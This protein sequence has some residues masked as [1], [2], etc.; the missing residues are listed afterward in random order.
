VKTAGNAASR[1]PSRI[2]PRLSA[3]ASFTLIE[4]LAVMAVIVI[5][6][7]IIL[8]LASYLQSKGAQSRAQSEIQ[9]LESACE[10][11]KTDNGV[12][13]IA[14]GTTDVMLARSMGDPA[15]A[16]ATIYQ[17]SSL[18]L[19]AALTGDT[20]STGVATV[21]YFPIT[22]I[23]LS[24]TNMGMAISASNTVQFLMDPWGNSYGY[25][26]AG[27]ISGTNGYNPTFD[28]WSTGGNTTA[29]TPGSS[30]DVT[31][32]WVKNW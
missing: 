32:K 1:F 21:S 10:S 4:L 23:M 27:Q 7:A 17:N 13:P 25:S 19:Y 15:S 9:A 24:R 5:L 31:I 16:N 8:S 11:Y 22:P 3:K 20:N 30:G 18:F 14:T 26:T 2:R 29:P 12:Y 6:A 28:L